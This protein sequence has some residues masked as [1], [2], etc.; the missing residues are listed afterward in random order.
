MSIKVG[1]GHS[2]LRAAAA[3]ATALLVVGGVAIANATAATTITS[4]PDGAVLFSPDVLV[5]GTA[6]PS[7]TVT[8]S[9]VGAPLAAAVASSSGAWSTTIHVGAGDHVIVATAGSS[10]SDPR[11]FKI[12][13]A[14]PAPAVTAPA[15]G[16][17]LGSQDVAFSGTGVRGATV[18]I[19]EKGSTEP[20]RCGAPVRSDLG[21]TWSCTLLMSEGM[22]TVNVWQADAAGT[23]GTI[24]ERRFSVDKTP[25]T[26]QITS[27]VSG[28]LTNNS[29]VVFAGT[30]ESEATVTLAVDGQDAGTVL[31]DGNGKWAI[32]LKLTDGGARGGTAHA[33]AARAVDSTGNVGEPSAPVTVT[34]DTFAPAAPAISSPSE[35][36]QLPSKTVK[37]EGTS[38]PGAT[39]TIAALRGADSGPA[40]GVADGSGAWTV[41]GTASEGAV[42]LTAVATDAARNASA[43]SAA[44]V[45]TVDA[46]A[47]V[48]TITTASPTVFTPADSAAAIEGT[49]SDGV[50]LPVL[51]FALDGP[52]PGI[53]A[54]VPQPTV[55]ST[56]ATSVS[57]SV[58][59]SSLFPG[60][61]T[62]TVTARDAAGN[63]HSAS[64]QFVK[65]G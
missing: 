21:D 34:V 45:V 12:N 15:D 42:S 22:H 47:P 59:V 36:A 53:N 10:Q 30:T 41:T 62:L 7:T 40:T 52:L 49:A 63:T 18:W 65:I 39:I 1:F 33:I 13:T 37:V 9:E 20:A 46:T 14:G 8:V 38:E 5:A 3:L 26:V 4:P 11:G 16:A 60:V 28:T 56:G 17:A 54:V 51:S 24:V 27:P 31:A 58:P 61:Y 23:A 48:V 50:S 35:G 32:S 44:R 25:P 55:T 2:R 57:F 64:I 19:R 43:A 6:E 29:S